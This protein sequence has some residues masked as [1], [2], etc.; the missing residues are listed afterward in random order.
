MTPP[1]PQK[2]NP[3]NKTV[4]FSKRKIEITFDEY[5]QLQN[6]NQELLVSP[7]MKEKPEVK[8]KAAGIVIRLPDKLDSNTTYNMNFG[9]SIVDLNE[10]NPAGDFQYVFSTGGH[11]D[12]LKISGVVKDAFTHAPEKELLVLLFENLNDS[13]FIND[14]ALYVAKVNETG[15]FTIPNIRPGTYNLFALKDENSNYMF[16]LPNE[17]I[18]FLDSV[19][20]PS[21]RTVTKTDTLTIEKIDTLAAETADTVKTITTDTITKDTVISRSYTE[22]SP[23]NITLYLFEEAYRQ[24]Y[25]SHDERTEK[26]KCKICFNRPLYDDFIQI[27]LSPENADTNR[28]FIEQNSYMDTLTCWIKD[29]NDYLRDSL[30]FLVSFFIKDSNDNK[31]LTTDTLYMVQKEKTKRKKDKKKHKDNDTLIIRTTIKAKPFDLNKKIIISASHPA[32]IVDTSGIRLLQIQDSL[33][34]PQPFSIHAINPVQRDFII[35]NIWEPDSTY[36]LMI[37]PGAFTDIF[38]FQNDTVL[39]RFTVQTPAYYGVIK[40]SIAGVDRA[41]I[42]E[43][44]NPEYIVKRTF[45]FEKDTMLIMKYLHP[46]KYTFR[47]IIDKNSNKLWDTGKYIEKRQPEPVLYLPEMIEVKSNYEHEIR[48]VMPEVAE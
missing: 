46:G 27:R 6:V 16:D 17:N 40:L 42:L 1:K 5:I 3:A 19:L 12:S 24:Q 36:Q 28:L 26:W 35:D 31:I 22:F 45:F 37:D 7:L 48:W 2:I 10:G 39:Q 41:T 34:I 9:Q 32:N 14:T 25:I 33:E 21:A 44:L 38:G 8:A 4:N 20:T 47:I 11:I 13:A 43:L 15:K 18:A 30:K 29:S 23:K